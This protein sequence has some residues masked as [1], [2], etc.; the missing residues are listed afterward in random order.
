MFN[1][2]WTVMGFP[3]R[4]RDKNHFNLI[5]NIAITSTKNIKSVVITYPQGS[6]NCLLIFFVA[7]E[8]NSRGS[9]GEI[10]SQI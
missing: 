4:K 1:Y 3:N 6:Y 10:F 2:I 7:A 5:Y 9:R 8:H